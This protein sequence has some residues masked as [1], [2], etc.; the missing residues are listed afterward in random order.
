M[1]RRKGEPQNNFKN[2]LV[3]LIKKSLSTLDFILLQGNKI[4]PEERCS[5]WNSKAKYKCHQLIT[6]ESLTK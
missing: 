5:I 3:V 6:N 4:Q 1:E 2:I